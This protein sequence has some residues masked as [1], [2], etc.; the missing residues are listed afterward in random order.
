MPTLKLSS[1]V[2]R[3]RCGAVEDV[4]E[5][6]LLRADPAGREREQRGQALHDEHE[7]GVVRVVGTWN[8]SRKK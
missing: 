8:A 6:A 7:Q 1:S 4:D 5:E 2:R 3:C